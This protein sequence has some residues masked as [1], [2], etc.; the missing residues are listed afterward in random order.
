VRRTVRGDNQ[1]ASR[2]GTERYVLWATSFGDRLA[3]KIVTGQKV[4]DC[5]QLTFLIV[6]TPL[7]DA[8]ALQRSLKY[9]GI[10]TRLLH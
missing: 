8:N 7:N 10:T 9:R 1:Y 2:F 6:T 4:H 3:D 5:W